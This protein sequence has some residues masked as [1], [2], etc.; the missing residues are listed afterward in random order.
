[1][2]PRQRLESLKVN[3]RSVSV[4]LANLDAFL[5]RG[6]GR[7]RGRGQ[8]GANFGISGKLRFRWDRWFEGPMVE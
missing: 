7:G 6:R 2:L 5:G 3:R 4:D 1:M 8:A